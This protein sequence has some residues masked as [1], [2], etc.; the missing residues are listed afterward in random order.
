M[1][2]KKADGSN[3]VVS[4][5]TPSGEPMVDHPRTEAAG[6]EDA[7]KVLKAA[8]PKEDGDDEEPDADEDDE[9][10]P[11]GVP[12]GLDKAKKSMP[13]STDDLEKSLSQLQAIATAGKPVS[14]KEALLKK[15]LSTELN[16]AEKAELFKAMAG[17]EVQA[18]TLSKS[19]QDTY[20]GNDV[21]QKATDVSDYLDE[22]Q[23]ALLKSLSILSDRVEA[24]GSRQHEFNLVLAKTMVGVGKLVKGMSERLGIIEAQPARAP[25]SRGVQPAQVLHKGFGGQD[26]GSEQLSQNQILAGLEGLMEKSLKEGRNGFTENGADIGLAT[27][28]FEQVREISPKMLQEISAFRQGNSN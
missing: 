12:P 15:A 17:P 13:L 21:L 11:E 8:E 14:R 20:A 10:K 7:A 25:K 2:L 1:K 6:D 26:N 28:K 24:D 22:S 27:A 18:P 16:K 4:T 5:Q 3:P 19:I 23:K 9:K